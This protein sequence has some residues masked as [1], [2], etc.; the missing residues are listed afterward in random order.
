MAGTI[1]YV[2]NATVSFSG[3]KALNR[4]DFYVDTG[5]L[6][7]LIGPNGAGKTTLLD[8]ICGK[9]KPESGR[10]IFEE[11]LDVGRLSE[12]RIARSGISRKFQTPSIFENLTLFENMELALTKHRG[13]FSSFFHK[14]EVPD[15][16][17][18]Y[19]LLAKVGLADHADGRA[20]FLSHGQKQWLELAMTILQEPRLLLVDEPVA[21]MT[22]VERTKTGE[23]LLEIARERSVLVVEHDMNFVKRFARK[24]TV[25]HEGRILCEGTFEHVKNDPVV[26]DVY[27]GR[28]GESETNALN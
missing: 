9:V 18:I 19:G 24:V 3:F 16:D 12:H 28:G 15:R 5:E 26:I 21:G 1:V 14:T 13:L 23:I 27:L 8:V 2:E 4:V 25:L 17:R 7:F 10:V 20:G 22:G 11:K 6:R